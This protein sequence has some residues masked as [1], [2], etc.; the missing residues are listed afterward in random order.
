MSVRSGT[1]FLLSDYYTWHHV[2]NDWYLDDTAD[3]VEAWFIEME[4][5]LGRQFGNPE[6][7]R[8][9]PTKIRR[10]IE[11]SWERIFNIQHWLRAYPDSTI[12][13]TVAQLQLPDVV[14]A[15]PLDAPTGV[16]RARHIASVVKRL[17]DKL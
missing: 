7:S 12:Q 5:R 17:T 2:L 16:N 1:S 9:W 4:R 14:Q 11:R 13:G 10:E 3:N 8:S 6:N 15:F